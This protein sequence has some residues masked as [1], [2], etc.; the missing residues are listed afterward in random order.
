MDRNWF[1]VDNEDCWLKGIINDHFL[2]GAFTILSF[3]SFWIIFALLLG[4]TKL[5]IT[6]FTMLVFI[7]YLKF[8]IFGNRIW[9]VHDWFLVCTTSLD[10]SHHNAFHAKK[11]QNIFIEMHVFLHMIW[12]QKPLELEKRELLTPGQAWGVHIML[13]LSTC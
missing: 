2:F 7:F 12:W 5:T 6:V 10:Q 9:L 3:P 11:R 13:S 4:Q 1:F 8:F